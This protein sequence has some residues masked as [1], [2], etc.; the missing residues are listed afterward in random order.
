MQE[1]KTKVLQALMELGKPARPGEIAQAAGLPK[2]EVSQAIK[3]AQGGKENY[4][5]QTLRIRP[6]GRLG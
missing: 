4:L 3:G 6:N 5:A 1:V 2:D